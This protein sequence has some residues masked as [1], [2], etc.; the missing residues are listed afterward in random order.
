MK[1]QGWKYGDMMRSLNPRTAERIGCG[2]RRET[3]RSRRVRLQFDWLD[4]D[5]SA[6]GDGE[7]FARRATRR[8]KK[9]LGAAQ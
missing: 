7:T 4:R 2:N 8:H 6:L 3:N 5:S 1:A 9:A